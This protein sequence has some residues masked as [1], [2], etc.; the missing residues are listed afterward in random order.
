METV[1]LFETRHASSASQVEIGDEIWYGRL[2]QHFR[3]LTQ[4]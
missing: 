2:G 3:S 4:S 1:F